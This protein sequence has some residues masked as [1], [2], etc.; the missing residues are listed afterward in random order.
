MTK[1]LM[2]T[3]G[4]GRSVTGRIGGGTE[5]GAERLA[6]WLR[7][8]CVDVYVIGY[9]GDISFPS[10]GVFWRITWPVMSFFFGLSYLIFGSA[11]VI[12]ARYCTYPLFVGVA[13]KTI[14]RKKL[15]AS[16]HGGDIRHGGIAGRIITFC[17]RRCDRVVCYDNDG[18]VKE[19]KRRGI[20]PIVIPNGIETDVF[21]PHKRK[22][23]IKKAIYAGGTRE[24][25][26]FID[27]IKASNVDTLKTQKGFEIHVYADGTIKSDS[28]VKFHN[29]VPHESLPKVM[30]SGQL[31]VLP[32]YAEGVPSAML[33]AMSAGMYVIASDLDFTRKILNKKFLFRA[34]DI[35]AITKLLIKFRDDMEGFF[36][37]QDVNNRKIAVEKYSMDKCGWK[38]K[39]LI[40]GLYAR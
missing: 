17:M 22:L 35:N 11:D 21:K 10:P 36:Q 37:D 38:W 33:E 39:I 2:L 19:L 24:I 25:K 1:V 13:L 9:G 40:E 18:H 7:K 12:Y 32:S 23:G 16:V 34:G 20:D 31:F 28:V 4:Y 30:E 29:K 15:V 5:M 14:F 26:G 3:L 8:N 27:I 6:R